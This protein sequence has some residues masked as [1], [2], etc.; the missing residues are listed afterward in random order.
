VSM[1]AIVS[2]VR[3]S[4]VGLLERPASELT[5]HQAFKTDQKTLA[6]W[7]ADCAE[8]VLPFFEKKHPEDGRPRGAIE[9]CRAWAAAG[10]FKMGDVRK[11]ALG[12]HAAARAAKQEDAAAAARAAGHAIATAHV[13]THAIGAAAYAIKAAAAHSNDLDDG[14]VRERDWQLRRLRRIA[15]ARRRDG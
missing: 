9:A 10:V 14:I 8:H 12:A 13:P 3:E 11:A 6:I 1:S 7:A 15:D 2:D 4:V 5:G